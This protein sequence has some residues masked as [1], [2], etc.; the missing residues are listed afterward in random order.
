MSPP[1][2]NKSSILRQ[3]ALWWIWVAGLLVVAG[4]VWCSLPPK[5]EGRTAREWLAFS[6]NG[7]TSARAAARTAFQTLGAEAIPDLIRA[8]QSGGSAPLWRRAYDWVGHNVLGRP[9]PRRG[10]AQ[11]RVDAA[12]AIR[13]IGPKG[14]AAIPQIVDLARDTHGWVAVAAIEGLGSIGLPALPHLKNALGSPRPGVRATAVHALANPAFHPR[15]DEFLPT[16][17]ALASDPVFHVRL[18]VIATLGQLRDPAGLPV[19]LAALREDRDQ[20]GQIRAAASL[21]DFGPAAESIADELRAF[22]LGPARSEDDH[23]RIQV[24]VALWNATRQ[25]NEAIPFLVRALR[26]GSS[27]TDGSQFAAEALGRMGPDAALA[28]PALL[29]C[30]TE[31]TWGGGV[32]PAALAKIGPTAVPGLV[33]LL[34]HSQ[35]EVRCRA[36]HAIEKQGPSAASAA[37]ALLLLLDDPFHEVRIAAVEALSA[38]GSSAAP[39]LPRLCELATPSQESSDTDG[40]IAVFAELAVQRITDAQPTSP[41]APQS[42]P[43]R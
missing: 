18:S 15:R 7:G 28:V 32:V 20:F 24:A 13:Q 12:E 4:L 19:L 11:L 34:T 35:S 30:L 26:L 43:P 27:D 1:S 31:K 38:I 2:A 33:A 9:D 25:T 40:E 37:P 3:P 22:L 23:L 39:A 5:Y 36:A 41:Q 42:V 21:A 10:S 8:V 16:L 17:I 14:A 6:A 29:D